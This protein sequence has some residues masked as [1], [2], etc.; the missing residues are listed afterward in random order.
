[1]RDRL[2]TAVVALYVHPS[3]QYTK[4]ILSYSD[5]STSYSE[6]KLQSLLPL[7]F[8]IYMI[9]LVRTINF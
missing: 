1:M 9:K 6:K 4:N 2:H 7:M 8:L 3:V 5:T